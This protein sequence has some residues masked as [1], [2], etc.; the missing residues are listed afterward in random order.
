MDSVLTPD[1][2]W[3]IS[4]I[5]VNWNSRED[6]CNCLRSLEAQVDRDFETIVVDNGSTDGS[7]SAV[8]ELFPWVRLLEAG[9]NLGF[10]EGCNR[11]I[12]VATGAWI[13]TLNNDACVDPEWLSTLRTAA[14][15]G[16]NRLGMLQ[17][18]LVFKHDPSL[19]N[20]TG[21][22]LYDNG[23]SVDR[24]FKRP[25]AETQVDPEIF[26]ASAGAALYRREMLDEIRLSTGVFDRTFFMYVEDVDLGWRARLAGW[27]ARY[28]PDAVVRHSFQGSSR[29]HANDFVGWQCRK[30]RLRSLLKNGSLPFILRTTPLTLWNAVWVL[31]TRR[32]AGLRELIAAAS[33]ATALRA[34]IEKVAKVPRREIERRWVTS[35]R[36]AK[37]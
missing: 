6:L 12:D 5:V 22:L 14:R 10:A 8:R 17:S 31:R 1:T 2:S 19:L 23:N 15:A 18:K 7:A 3:T 16:G 35:T 34:E 30:N 28:V 25:S 20:S 32:L 21:V 29:R 33:Q 37:K 11:A 26:C 9:E 13:A 24:H 27:E 4:V 36:A